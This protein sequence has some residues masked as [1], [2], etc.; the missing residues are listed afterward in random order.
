MVNEAG[1]HDKGY[2][3]SVRNIPAYCSGISLITRRS[4]CCIVCKEI[5]PTYTYV[6]GTFY[7]VV[8]SLFDLLIK[9]IENRLVADSSV[10]FD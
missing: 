5:P 1:E 6:G 7:R 10:F 2:V 8:F 3:Q 9:I 4:E